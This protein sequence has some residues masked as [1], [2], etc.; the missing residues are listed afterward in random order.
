MRKLIIVL[1]NANPHSAESIGTPIFQASVAASMGHQVEVV[2]TGAATEILKTGVA[3]AIHIK[4]AEARSIHDLIKEAHA[5]GARFHC[6]STGLDAC[7]MSKSDLISE[8]SGVIGAAHFI[9]EIMDG[10]SQV[11]TY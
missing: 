2:F 8:C 1:A 7:A 5:A 9:E 3:Q 10:N 11:L 6:F 4:T